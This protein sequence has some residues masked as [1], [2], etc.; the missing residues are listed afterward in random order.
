[1]ARNQLNALPAGSY[2]ENAIILFTDGLENRPKT[3]FRSEWG[4]R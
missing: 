2:D 3:I 1:M 4:H